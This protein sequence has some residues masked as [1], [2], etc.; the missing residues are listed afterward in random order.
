MQ[1]PTP[2][3]NYIIRV[4]AHA[5]VLAEYSVEATSPEEAAKI[6]EQDPSKARIASSPV[7]VNPLRM[8]MY[9]LMVKG[10]NVYTSF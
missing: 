2:K 9:R 7:I 5:D 10:T 8:R 1:R 6:F 3:R 4:E